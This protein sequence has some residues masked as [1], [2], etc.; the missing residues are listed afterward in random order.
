MSESQ[1]QRKEFEGRRVNVIRRSYGLKS[2]YERLREA[3]LLT[4]KGLAERLGISSSGVRARHRRVCL[5]AYRVYDSRQCLYEDCTKT[6]LVEDN[7]S[8]RTKEVQYE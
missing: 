7:V 6:S 5:K 4:A 2:Q 1:G 8:G 3:G